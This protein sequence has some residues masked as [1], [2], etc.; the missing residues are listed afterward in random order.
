MMRMSKA[1]CYCNFCSSPMRF[2][3]CR[4]GET[5][6]C[7]N[8][9]M[10]TVLFIPG[11][12]PPYAEEQ[13]GLEVREMKWGKNQFGLRHVEGVVQN[14]SSKNLDWARIEF[15]LSDKAGV[16]VG[17]TSDCL[18]SLPAKATWKFQAPV[19]QRET[20]WLLRARALVAR[21]FRRLFRTPELTKAA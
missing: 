14:V 11:L 4:V 18:I 6:N 16:A 17:S 5:V 3:F 20:D 21:P 8:C 1:N 13:Y 15:I 12:A 7:F 9:G 19:I 2:E 10:E